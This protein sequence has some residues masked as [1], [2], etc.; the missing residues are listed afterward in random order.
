MSHVMRVVSSHDLR[1]SV[2]DTGRITHT[3]KQAH[4]TPSLIKVVR[5]MCLD[6][7]AVA[8]V[9]SAESAQLSRDD[10]CPRARVYLR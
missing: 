3:S 4:C 6:N 2:A 8:W 5:K 1:R 7:D 9:R 10:S